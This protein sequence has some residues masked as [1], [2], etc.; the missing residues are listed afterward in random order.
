[1]CGLIVVVHKKEKIFSSER[2]SEALQLMKH[3]GPDGSKVIENG[4]VIIGNNRLAI[5]DLTDRAALPLERGP[6]T[7]ALNGSIFNYLNLNRLWMKDVSKAESK[8]DAEVLIPILRTNDPSK[9]V[10]VDGMYAIIYHDHDRH[11]LIITRDRLGIKPLYEY[12]D[13]RVIVYSS[14]IKPMLNLLL[15]FISFNNT[16]IQSYLLSESSDT[17]TSVYFNEISDFPPGGYKTMDLRNGNSNLDFIPA[18]KPTDEA[19]PDSIKSMLIQSLQLR[20]TADWPIS[21]SYS[22]GIDSSI[23]SEIDAKYIKNLG[24]RFRIGT[25]KSRIPIEDDQ[26]VDITVSQIQKPILEQVAALHARPVETISVVYQ[27][28][29]YQRM[30][31]AGY[32]VSISGQGADELFFGYD[33]HR[34]SLMRSFIQEKKWGKFISFGIRLLLC[35]PSLFKKI[36]KRLTRLRSKSQSKIIDLLGKD[37]FTAPLASLLEYEDI[38]GMG[39]GVEVRH[40][41]I[42]GP[43]IEAML[44]VSPEVAISPCQRKP[45]LVNSLYRKVPHS[46]R[47]GAKD[48]FLS[49]IY[50]K[51][52]W[53]TE[54][55]HSLLRW[56]KTYLTALD[57][58]T[59]THTDLGKYRI[60]MGALWHKH[61]SLYIKSDL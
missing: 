34:V 16:A 25:N 9:L 22:G 2:V 55:I 10:E 26:I 5:Y 54:E 29:L 17:L 21:M 45:I 27:Y 60:I 52:W 19:T 20:S 6:E 56:A 57:F 48:S 36:L 35:N 12:E 42:H 32:R 15:P 31:A 7:L 51:G 4:A 50:P 53:E 13:E 1:M 43:L 33:A 11:R 44:G 47:M 38:N 59:D 24:S 14:E 30:N 40:P 46:F 58:E 39:H 18:F 8:S 28:L 61:Y 37:R 49:E 23:L 3:R 41:Y